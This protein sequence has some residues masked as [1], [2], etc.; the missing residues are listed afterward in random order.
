MDKLLKSRIATYDLLAA[1]LSLL[2]DDYLKEL[3]EGASHLGNC[4]FRS[5]R[6]LVSV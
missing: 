3:I 2:S 4:V 1:Q 6:T 5:E